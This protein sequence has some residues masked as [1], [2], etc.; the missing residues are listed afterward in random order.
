MTLGLYFDDDSG[1]RA[2]VRALRARGIVVTTPSEAGTLGSP[3]SAHLAFA[4]QHGLVVCT[5]NVGDFLRLHAELMERGGE[6]A[7]I[8]LIPQQ[9]YP[10]GERMR[11]LLNLMAELP[12]ERMRNWVEFL[13]DWG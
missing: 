6:H 8:I 13:S 5:S 9:V 4:A 3:D 2:L 10:V 12:P 7:G 11:R 1:E